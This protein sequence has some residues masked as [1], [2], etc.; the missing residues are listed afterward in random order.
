MNLGFRTSPQ[1]CWL[2]VPPTMNFPKCS[3]TKTV[4]YYV[5]C[6][7]LIPFRFWEVLLEPFIASGFGKWSHACSIHKH[8]VYIFKQP[9]NILRTFQIALGYLPGVLVKSQTLLGLESWAT[10]SSADGIQ[11]QRAGR[12]PEAGPSA[13]E[14]YSMQIVP[15]S[16]LGL[17]PIPQV[18]LTSGEIYSISSAKLH[19]ALCANP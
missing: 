1:Q 2:M 18:S 13:S 4:P 15:A 7:E 10:S 8:K 16:T 11:N 9:W 12:D 3:H 14:G 6:F 17:Q 19:L 5:P